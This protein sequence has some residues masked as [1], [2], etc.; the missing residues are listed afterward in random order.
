MKYQI[1]DEILVLHSNEEGKVVEIINDKM[2]MIEV[3]GV[4]F[5]A[6]MD[7][8]DF[9]YFKRFTEKKLVPEKKPKVYVDQIKTEKTPLKHQQPLG[10]Q[11]AL[12]PK[13]GR[14][15]FN[16]EVVELFKVYLINSYA[17]GLSF[18][19]QY[20][21]KEELVFELNSEVL[22]FHEFYLHDIPFEDISDN[23]NIFI[24]FSLLKP[25][26][27]KAPFYETHLKLKGKQIFKKLEQIQEENLPSIL[28][29]LMD[30][31]PDQ[32]IDIFQDLTALENKGY[33]IK[34]WKNDSSKTAPR[35]LVD[36]HIDKLENN[37]QQLNAFEIL[38]I[39][40]A[41]LEQWVNIAIE[42]HMPNLIIIHGVGTGKLRDE[43]HQF[44][45]TKKEVSSFVNQY[46]PNFGHGATEVFFKY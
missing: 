29:K 27:Q 8:I 18:R 4:K 6:Y 31:Y 11:I 25:E 3:R 42:H 15:E 13:Y 7:Q 24:E 45:K 1:G 21:I 41:A 17:K 28:F 9:P 10:I 5:P 26:K 30:E 43:V 19:Y 44:L 34:S 2:L 23:P 35:S 36:L 16:D 33:Q 37:W 32:P 14:D 40:L 38:Q 46:H 39:Q 12:I 20:E 22:S